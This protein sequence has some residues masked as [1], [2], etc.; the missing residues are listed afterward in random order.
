MSLAEN[1]CP[2]VGPAIQN[3]AMRKDDAEIGIVIVIRERE[4]N[5]WIMVEIFSDSN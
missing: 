5:Y 1:H 3:T 2:A 4:N